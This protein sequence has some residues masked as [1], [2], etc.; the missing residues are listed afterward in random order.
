VGDELEAAIR[1]GAISALRTR[2]ERQAAI[3]ADGTTVGE[4][5]AIIQT[6]EAAIAIVLA[7]TFASLANEL[8]RE[9]AQ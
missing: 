8:E 5:G 1:A 9:G 2:A 6:G 3:A 7:S 4:R